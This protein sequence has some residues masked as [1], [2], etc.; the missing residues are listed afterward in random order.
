M[1]IDS[2]RMR[3]FKMFF[4]WCRFDE[5]QNM[6]LSQ[7]FEVG[8]ILNF[9]ELSYN[10]SVPIKWIRFFVMIKCDEDHLKQTIYNWFK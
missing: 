3:K 4:L 5:W 2:Y 10:I 8:F 7:I 1:N 9:I 6:E